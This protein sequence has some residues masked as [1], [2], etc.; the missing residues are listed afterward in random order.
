M[1]VFDLLPLGL[2]LLK[3]NGGVAHVNRF[4]SEILDQSDGLSVASDPTQSFAIVRFRDAEQDG[5][6]R[7]SRGAR[8][9]RYGVPVWTANVE[10]T[11]RHT[12]LRAIVFALPN[13]TNN[14]VAP[15]APAALLVI[16]DPDAA[17]SAASE[18][19]QATFGLSPAEIRVVEAAIVPTSLTD[20]AR[21]LGISVNTTKTH[22]R[23][24]YSKTGVSSRHGLLDLTAGMAHSAGAGIRFAR[25]AGGA[26]A[27]D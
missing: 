17:W 22:L 1:G 6:F 4:A 26:A 12:P 2:I 23:G 3:R 7:A 19:L 27:T 25:Q 10:R 11:S 14:D 5:E 18:L 20:L 9:P 21:T 16:A 15:D 8:A 24:V 13:G